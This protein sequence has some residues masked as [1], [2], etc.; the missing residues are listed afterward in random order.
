MQPDYIPVAIEKES[1]DFIVDHIV[2]HDIA[3]ARDG[4][5]ERGP[6][7]V[8]KVRLAGYDESADT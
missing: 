5:Y 8:F 2:E 6:Y 7:L 3:S 1:P 4:F